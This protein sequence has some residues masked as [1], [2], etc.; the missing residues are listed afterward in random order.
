MITLI[1]ARNL[2]PG[3]ILITVNGNRTPYG[4]T[5]DH[6]D[7]NP[8]GTIRI[9]GTR[10]TSTESKL[11]YRGIRPELQVSVQRGTRPA[12]ALDVAPA[13]ELAIRQIRADIGYGRVPSTVPDFSALHDHVDANEYGGLCDPVSGIDWI[14][15]EDESNYSG[16]AV[17]N[18]VNSWIKAGMPADWS[19]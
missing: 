8:S 7:I 16:N 6:V 1:Y 11:V 13:V 9:Y 17:Q 3:D 2:V 14:D 18:S 19:V 5:V 10:H 12:N 4:T 15:S